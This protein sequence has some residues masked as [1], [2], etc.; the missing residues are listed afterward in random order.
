MVVNATKLVPLVRT[1]T[2]A[3][4]LFIFAVY[5]YFIPQIAKTY[6]SLIRPTF[7]CVLVL[8]K[9]ILW[10]STLVLFHA[11]PKTHKDIK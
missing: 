10:Y 7:I 6:I 5:L 9:H 3:S 1:N 4:L 11:S 2:V 8:C